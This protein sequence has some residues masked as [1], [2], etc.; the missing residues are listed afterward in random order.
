MCISG[1]LVQKSKDQFF[2]A[3]LIAIASFFFLKELIIPK[4]LGVEEN[5]CYTEKL[6]PSGELLIKVRSDKIIEITRQLESQYELEISK[7]F[8]PE[9]FD[10]T[11]LDDFLLID[12]KASQNVEKIKSKLV[13]HP[14][15]LFVEYN[16]KCQID[17]PIVE[18]NS[19]NVGFKSR[20]NDPMSKNQ[21]SLDA[22]GMHNVQ[23]NSL[24]SIPIRKTALLVILDSGVEGNHEDLQDNY[25]EINRN[26]SQDLTGHG[27][28]C[29][30]IAAAVTN[31]QIG[32]ASLNPSHKWVQVSS[33][34][35]M[36]SLGFGTQKRII[37]GMIEASD[38]GAEVISLSLGSRKFLTDEDY[39]YDEAVQ[40][41]N[42]RGTI[43]VTSAGNS[44]ADASQFSP[45]SAQNVIGVSSINHKLERS[46]FSNTIENIDFGLAA[47]GEDIL[48][49]FLNN[50]YERKSGTSMA[51]PYVASSIALLKAIKPEI[52]TVEA[53]ELLKSTGRFID[54]QTG[55]LI[56]PFEAV[57]KLVNKE[58]L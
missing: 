12:I 58:T 28:H 53:F 6:D 9:I 44:N 18:K 51:A 52:T 7:A 33:I 29:A 56:Q 34:R 13:L 23:S 10:K 47:P 14:D 40:Y 50:N 17:L 11:Q 42:M 31:N 46:S 5:S 15:I 1:F 30:G 16:E 27:T 49:T 36:N 37:E 57:Q 25:L 39:A 20:A 2:I 19:S 8:D 4:F 45:V 41:C 43:V 32:I 21:W 48:S 38:L 55:Y 54:A 3:C 26:Y 24:T 22:L 35:V